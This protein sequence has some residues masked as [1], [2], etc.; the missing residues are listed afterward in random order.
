MPAKR[1]HHAKGKKARAANRDGCEPDPDHDSMSFADLDPGVNVIGGPAGERRGF[2][3]EDLWELARAGIVDHA[4]GNIK[5][6]RGWFLAQIQERLVGEVA[7]LEAKRKKPAARPPSLP[8]PLFTGPLGLS[9]SHN[10]DSL[11]DDASEE[12]VSSLRESADVEDSEGEQRRTEWSRGEEEQAPPTLPSEEEEEEESPP[13]PQA[14]PPPRQ[15]AQPVVDNE[16]DDEDWN[17]EPA[18][19]ATAP[20]AQPGKTQPA[21]TPK[22]RRTLGTGL[23]STGALAL[24]D[25][26]RLEGL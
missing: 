11:D 19:Q 6:V 13:R 3:P 22:A 24:S 21:P 10:M 12:R 2:T 8:D 14:K 17:L 4:L 5:R 18:A 16:T 25:D 20:A 1:V 15:A 26:D 23:F 7:A 9:I